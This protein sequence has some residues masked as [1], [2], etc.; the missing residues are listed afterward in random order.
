MESIRQLAKHLKVSHTTVSSHMS[1]LGITGES[2]G[3]GKPTLIS[4][5]DCLRIARSINPVLEPPAVQAVEVVVETTAIESIPQPQYFV[6]ESS[7]SRQLDLHRLKGSIQGFKSNQ[8]RFRD[9]MLSL[10]IEQGRQ[11]GHEM[12]AAMLDTTFATFES[13]GNETSEE[14]GLTQQPSDD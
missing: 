6:P 13:V 11:L 10:A 2:Q 3:E 4:E 14:L 9:A 1:R 5:D 12:K 7:F 8:Q